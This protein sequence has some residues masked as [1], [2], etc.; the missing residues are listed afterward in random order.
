M[1]IQK[2]VRAQG[3]FAK[4]GV[5][6]KDGDLV[7]VLDTGTI[8]TGD[9]GDRHVFKIKTVNG[10]KVLTF[11]QTSLNNI[12][13]GYGDET[14]TWV[15]KQVKLWI[16]RQM[17]SNKLTNVVYITP[18]DWVMTPDGKF[19]PLNHKMDAGNADLDAESVYNNL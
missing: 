12:I 1:K 3:E 18:S 4:V 9:Y 7:T 11:N 13:D 10:E 6:I 19:A 14:E 17:V 5:D 8:V 2:I 15:G 16:I